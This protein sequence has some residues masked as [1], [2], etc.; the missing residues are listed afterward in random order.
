VV[1][2]LRPYARQNPSHVYHPISTGD[3]GFTTERIVVIMADKL[4]CGPRYWAVLVGINFYEK[5]PLKGCVRDVERFKHYVE[6][7]ST[8]VL[9]EAVIATAGS[10]TSRRPTEK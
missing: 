6:T 2:Y 7:G 9:I 8:L 4:N 1:Q 3:S 10:S 5:N